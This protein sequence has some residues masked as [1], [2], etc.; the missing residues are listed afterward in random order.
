MY[1]CDK[2][3]TMSKK[4]TYNR[5]K[6]IIAEEKKKLKKA[7]LLSVDDVDTVEDAWAGGD[8]LVNHVDFIKKLGIKE[9]KLRM[10]AEKISKARKILKNKLI[11]D[12]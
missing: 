5:L 1:E 2:G 7:G 6:K 10:K 4:L 11:R 3:E 8:N 12:L 9:A